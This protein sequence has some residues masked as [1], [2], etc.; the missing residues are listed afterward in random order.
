[1]QDEIKEIGVLLDRQG[2]LAETRLGIIDREVHQMFGHFAGFEV[3]EDGERV[4]IAGLL[5][6]AE[7]HHAGW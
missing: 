6:F 7:D 3:G 4:E 1:M 5:G 2:N